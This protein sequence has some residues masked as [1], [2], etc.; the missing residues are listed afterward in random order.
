M[1]G[2][3]LR[4]PAT[5][6]HAEALDV[7]ASDTDPIPGCFADI[8]A[9]LANLA[10]GQTFTARELTGIAPETAARLQIYLK[11]LQAAAA[12]LFEDGKNPDI[13]E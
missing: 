9:S 11:E 10:V 7:R 2:S 6:P 1:N 3:T 4:Q 8:K 12:A 5:D 13:D